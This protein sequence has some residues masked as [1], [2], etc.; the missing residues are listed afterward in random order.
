MFPGKWRKDPF[1]AR[2]Y[3]WLSE[4]RITS[5]IG[6]LGCCCCCCAHSCLVSMSDE[7]FVAG[8]EEG[9][10]LQEQ[11]HTPLDGFLGQAYN[12]DD[13]DLTEEWMVSFQ[14]IGR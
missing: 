5:N 8:P 6:T 10:R 11:L 3:Q 2:T 7:V 12:Y 1:P 4:Y 14:D 13:H 9:V